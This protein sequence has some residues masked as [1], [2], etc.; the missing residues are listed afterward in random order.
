MAN[1][2]PPSTLDECKRHARQEACVDAAAQVVK[3]LL[4][5]ALVRLAMDVDGNFQNKFAEDGTGV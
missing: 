4:G 2:E 3:E 1:V 5:V